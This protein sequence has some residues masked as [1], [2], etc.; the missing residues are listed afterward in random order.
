ME[1][2]YWVRPE[3]EVT[4]MSGRRPGALPCTIIFPYRTRNSPNLSLAIAILSSGT[5]HPEIPQAVSDAKEEKTCWRR[6]MLGKAMRERMLQR[7]KG[8]RDIRRPKERCRVRASGREPTLATNETR[9]YQHTIR[10]EGRCEEEQGE[11][12]EADDAAGKREKAKC[13]GI[14][15]L[16]RIRTYSDF[17]VLVHVFKRERRIRR[18]DKM[19]GGTIVEKQPRDAERK[20]PTRLSFMLQDFCRIRPSSGRQ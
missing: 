5:V 20:F 4:W 13:P 12:G 3:S 16:W 10:L 6:A 1:R 18:L 17:L 15:A 2:S 19:D 7:W 8:G 9:S 14:P 11:E